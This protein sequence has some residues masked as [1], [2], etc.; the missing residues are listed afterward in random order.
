MSLR[1]K[2]EFEVSD[3]SADSMLEKSDDEA[4]LITTGRTTRSDELGATTTWLLYWFVW[5]KIKPLILHLNSSW[6]WLF[7]QVVPRVDL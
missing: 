2:L 5:L 1:R 4:E 3:D 6:F 7:E